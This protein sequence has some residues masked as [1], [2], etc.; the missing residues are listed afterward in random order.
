MQTI[1]HISTHP[2]IRAELAR[3]DLVRAEGDLFADLA[4]GKINL[5]QYRQGMA[6]LEQRKGDAA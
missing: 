1:K 4:H 6:E 3:R 2:G 5:E